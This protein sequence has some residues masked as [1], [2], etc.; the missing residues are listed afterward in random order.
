MALAHSLRNRPFK[1]SMVLSSVGPVRVGDVHVNG[2]DVIVISCRKLALLHRQ[3][4]SRNTEAILQGDCASSTDS[5][6]R[7][8]RIEVFE[9]RA[10]RGSRI[11]SASFGGVKA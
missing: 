7:Y 2:Y 11:K 10:R 4:S 6:N 9:D 1:F 5:I 3:S 8:Q